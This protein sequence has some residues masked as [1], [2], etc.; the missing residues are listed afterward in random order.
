MTQYTT[1]FITDAGKQMSCTCDPDVWELE[2]DESIPPP[3][4]KYE[5]SF[6]RC[7]LCGHAL[8]CHVAVTLS[9]IVPPGDLDAIV[10]K[11]RCH[12]E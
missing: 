5:D 6:G 1:H 10:S 7:N 12:F 3:C 2:R 4:D 11:I 9:D 8:L